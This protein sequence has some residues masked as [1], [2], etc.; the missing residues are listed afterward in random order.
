LACEKY[1]GIIFT[2]K[3]GDVID[4]NNDNDRETNENNTLEITEVDM[5][6]EMMTETEMCNNPET[7]KITGVGIEPET[8]DD[9]LYNKGVVNNSDQYNGRNDN[10]ISDEQHEYNISIEN[11]IPDDIHLTIN[12]INTVNEMNA[13]Q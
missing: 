1:K 5:T 4:K 8:N 2:D 6:T 9:E 12:D 10:D 7:N 3:N 11:E 13:M